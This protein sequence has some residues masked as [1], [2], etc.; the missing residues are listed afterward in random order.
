M[1]TPPR[2]TLV[3][4]IG[5]TNTKLVLFDGAGKAAARAA[6]RE[7]PCSRAALPQPRSGAGAGAAGRSAAGFRRRASGRRHRALR[8]RLGAGAARRGRR[9]RLAGDGLF[10]RAAG[11]DRRRLSPDRAALRGSVLPDQSDGADARAAAVLAGD[12]IP[13]AIRPRSHHPA[14]GPVFRLAHERPRGD[15][16]IPSSARRPSSSTSPATAS[17][18]WR[19]ARGW[20]RLFAPLAAPYETLGTLKPELCRSAARRAARDQGRHPRFQ[21]QLSPVPGR[22]ARRF[23]A[24]VDRHLDHH[25]RHR[26]GFP[27]PRPEP[28][29]R[30]QH[31]PVLA[32]GRLQPLHG[33]PGDRRGRGRRADRVGHAGG[34][35]GAGPPRHLRLALLHRFGRPDARHRR[36]RQ[37]RRAAAARPRRSARR[38]GRSIAR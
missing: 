30:H 38:W 32:P 2:G 13:R 10:R 25:L 36:S 9:A 33:R 35:F 19:A 14:L 34:A 20:D 26:I 1:P 6:R 22:R 12:H 11:R 21:R 24:A 16:A 15:R 4:D 28:R 23:H 7:P 3:L 27:P 29:H 17:R 18:R 5:S 8:A 31:R 37:D